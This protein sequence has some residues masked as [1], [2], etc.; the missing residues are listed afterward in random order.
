MDRKCLDCQLPL[1]G[2]TDK[3]FC[4]QLCRSSYYNKTKASETT[5]IREINKIL[6]NNRS[7]LKKLTPGQPKII[8]RRKLLAHGFDLNYITHIHETE[9]KDN[10]RFCYEYG[11]LLIDMEKVLLV[12]KK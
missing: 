5:V 7:I 10:Y 6:K 4:D 8:S 9:R 11:Y 2:R 12:R 1:K 3:K